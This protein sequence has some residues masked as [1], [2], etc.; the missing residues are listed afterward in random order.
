[1]CGI[2]C[3]IRVGSADSSDH[4]VDAEVFQALSEQLRSVNGAR[5]PDAQT[6]YTLRLPTS[7][8]PRDSSEGQARGSE[9]QIEFFASELMLRGRAV[10]VQPHQQE[11]DVFEGLNI[12]SEENDGVK[13]FSRF[14]LDCTPDSVPGLLGN[15]EGPY[16]FVFY[17]SSSEK[18]YFAR[19]PLGRRSLLIHKPSPLFPY[20]LLSS[21]SELRTEGI[22][23]L[24]VGLIRQSSDFAK[25]LDDYLSI[26]PR[27]ASA[28]KFAEI[29]RV[30]TTLP[31]EDMPLLDP[32]GSRPFPKAWSDAVDE[33]ISQLDR[34]VMLRVRDIPVQFGQEGKARVAVLFSG[35]I[36]STML[37]FLA[38][39]HVPRDEAID[40]INVAFE[41]PRKIQDMLPKRERK[42]YRKA[43]EIMKVAGGGTA[44]Y[45]VPDRVTGL[46]EVD[47]LRKLCPGRTWNLVEVDV[48]YEE[49]LA[50]RST[51]EAIMWPS[52]TVMDLSLAMA[53]Y[54]AS[55]GVGRIR[56][57]SSECY[58]AYTSH[59]RVLLNGLGSDEL[60]GGYG[61]HRTAFTVRGW[62]GILINAKLQLELDRIPTR[63]LGRDDRIISSHG[64]ETRHPFL[65]LSVVS[66]LAGLPV[67]LKLDPRLD[68]GKGDK[69]LLRLAARRVGLVEASARKKR[70]MQFGSHS[71]RM[72]AGE[73]ER[74]GD[75][76]IGRL[77]DT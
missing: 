58:K 39:R 40:L 68:V 10:V 32:F 13:L 4:C 41:N 12:N 29:S 61:R 30:N 48:P 45:L 7:H 37:A 20:L 18:L 53:L 59:A 67:Y 21:V 65:S 62:E 25:G 19:D 55:R 57:S 14:R 38:H 31:L 44:S 11:G 56:S 5:G 22:F 52:R 23:C 71:A 9:L 2:Y 76:V 27:R 49:S 63:N 60:L 8:P 15:V 64:K 73:G 36:D 43:G 6:S 42:K 72:E 28:A 74:R 70:A 17:D 1:M 54:F 50:A 24:D 46:E 3:S 66:F 69:T 47:E 51:V 35:G 26:I 75:L 34:S 77:V 16:A 33:L